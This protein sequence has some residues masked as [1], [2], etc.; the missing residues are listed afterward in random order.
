MQYVLGMY[1]GFLL[2]MLEPSNVNNVDGFDQRAEV[3]AN[4]QSLVP[5]LPCHQ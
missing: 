1:E 2:N 5:V 3:F 4:K